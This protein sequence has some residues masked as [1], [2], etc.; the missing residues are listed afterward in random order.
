MATNTIPPIPY[1]TPVNNDRGYV[2]EA[3]SKF[4][5]EVFYRIGGTSSATGESTTGLAADI[6]QL[7]QDI[8]DIKQGPIL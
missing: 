6:L 3:W 1:K 2:S 8:Q 4:F 5:L 7:Q